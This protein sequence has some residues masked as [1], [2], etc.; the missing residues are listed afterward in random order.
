MES[1]GDIENLPEEQRPE[2][3]AVI[4]RFMRYAAERAD[5][6]STSKSTEQPKATTYLGIPHEETGLDTHNAVVN[7]FVVTVMRHNKS[8]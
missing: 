6:E 3:R 1:L 4:G 7:D 8:D 2:L 5:N